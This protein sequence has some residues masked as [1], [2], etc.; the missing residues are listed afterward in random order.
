[1]LRPGFRR[2]R[3]GADAM[4]TS[5]QRRVERDARSGLKRVGGVERGWIGSKS[6]TRDDE[7][8]DGLVSSAAALRAWLFQPRASGPSR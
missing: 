1:L 3:D 7:L 8:P 5:I 6:V 2:C 4:A